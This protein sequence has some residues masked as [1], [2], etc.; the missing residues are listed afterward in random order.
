[1][2]MAE[3]DENF[4]KVEVLLT[5][6][7]NCRCV[8]CSFGD[9]TSKKVKPVEEIQRDLEFA[10]R[11]R[12]RIVSFSGGEP[13]IVK[14]LPEMMAKAKGLG[15]ERIEM[16][17]NGRMLCYEPYADKLVQSGLD[18]CVVS[19]HSHRPEISDLM[20]GVNGAFE[21]T[22]QG[23]KNLKGRG[24][25]VLVNVVAT[26]YNY[27][28][29]PELTKFLVDDLKV[30]GLHLIMVAPDGSARAGGKRVIPQMTEVAESF[31]KAVGY[32]RERISEVWTYN[33]PF[34]L[35]SGF[36]GAEVEINMSLTQLRAPDFTVSI[37]D[38]RFRDKAK[39]EKCRQCRFDAICQGAWQK[40]VDLYGDAEISP[41]A[42]TPITS[43]DEFRKEFPP[44]VRPEVE[45]GK[46]TGR[47]IRGSKGEKAPETTAPRNR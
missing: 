45:G 19:L 14:A 31:R 40:Y 18:V 29:I 36:E 20:M 15:F 27:K 24:V 25:Y 3:P 2:E 47:F 37:D 8:F 39:F 12:A 30:D 17:T 42:G 33:L 4:Q 9:K 1:M 28:E 5:L 35:C 41:V 46:K 7:C 26:Q 10:K 21:Q 11:N 6:A 43:A 16:Q 38:N 44:M 34:C 23:I 22:V 32:A 13:T